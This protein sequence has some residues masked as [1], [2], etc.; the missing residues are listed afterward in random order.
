MRI[1]VEVGVR[2]NKIH[3]LS[4][5]VGFISPETLSLCVDLGVILRE[6]S[7]DPHFNPPPLIHTNLFFFDSEISGV[8]VK[9]L[10][11][12]ESFK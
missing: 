9:L 11:S 3:Q 1:F 12:S 10:K 6:V 5:H 7:I 2:L 8:V 4:H